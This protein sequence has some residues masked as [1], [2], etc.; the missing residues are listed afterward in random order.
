MP[1]FFITLA[2]LTLESCQTT[3]PVDIKDEDLYYLKEASTDQWAV[4]MHFLSDGQAQVSQ[5]DWNV[6]SQGMVCMP[7]TEWSDINTEFGKLCTQITCDYEFQQAMALIS[8]RLEE[9]AK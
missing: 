3:V 7:L 5:T 2:T 4:E 9:V 6:K 1:L 8:E